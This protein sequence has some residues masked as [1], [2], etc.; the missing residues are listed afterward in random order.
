VP[1]IP[2]LPNFTAMLAPG[3]S[4]LAVVL[5]VVLALALAAGGGFWWGYSDGK[6]RADDRWSAAM[7]RR[8]TQF[9]QAQANATHQAYLLLENATRRGNEAERKF[10][11]SARTIQA[12]RAELNRRRIADASREVRCPDAG[13]GP[14]FPDGWVREYNAALG[15]G[16]G[17]DAL[18][19][20][21]PGADGNATSAG[22]AGPWV[23][24]G[25]SAADVL[26]HV[27]DVGAWCRTVLAQKLALDRWAEGRP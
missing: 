24:R 15:L 4:R 20:P 11:S 5:G 8:E 1:V 17:G 9:A 21:A 13:S 7:E 23:R 3:V 14:V 19:G 12:Q 26:A 27:A 25:V 16:H 10:L 6:S 22:A 2:V 18:P